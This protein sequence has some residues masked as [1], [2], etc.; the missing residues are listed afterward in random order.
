[1]PSP[2]D[3]LHYEGNLISKIEELERRLNALERTELSGVVGPQG[4][5]GATGAQG[6]A[7]PGTPSGVVQGDIVYYDATPEAAALNIGTAEQVLRVNAGAT[8]PEWSTIDNDSIA[9]RTRKLW[10]PGED[11]LNNTLGAACSRGAIRG[12]LLPD[13]NDCRVYGAFTCPSD[14]ASGM[15]INAIFE[16]GNAGNARVALDVWYGADGEAY[17]THTAAIAATDETLVANI[18]DDFT[19]PLSLANMAAGD[20]VLCQF[21]RD[22]AHANDT[23]GG[24]VMFVGFLVSYTADM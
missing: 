11:S 15:T 18:N 9:N 2:L 1:M 17:N 13:L 7:G 20:I 16:S 22:G 4:P 8:A 3:T 14:F 10:V 6:P 23:I 24:I 21:Q 19:T 5:T 12:W